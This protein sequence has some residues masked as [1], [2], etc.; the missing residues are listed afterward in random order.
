MLA[1]GVIML[2]VSALLGEYSHLSWTPRS[3]AAVVYL[4]FAGSLI[5][6]VAYTYALAHL[7]MSTVSLYPYVNPLVA[8]LLGTWLLHEPL[9]W[10]IAGAIAIVL[11]GSAV[12]SRVGGSHRQAKRA[13]DTG[14]VAEVEAA[15]AGA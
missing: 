14:A 1:G 13:T 12:V 15:Q 3:L 9:S 4:F 8:V 2:T 11:A 5:G 6:F 7:P 10:R